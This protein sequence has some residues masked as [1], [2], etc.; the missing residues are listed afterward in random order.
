MI[1]QQYIVTNKTCAILPAK[2]INHQAIVLEEHTTIKVAQTPLEIIKHSC[3][4]YWADYEGRRASVIK[5]L[6]YKQKTPIPVSV[7][8]KLCFLPTH[9]PTHMNNCWINR[10]HVNRWG[11]IQKDERTNE[12]QTEIL[13]NNWHRL[14]LGISI[15]TLQQQIERAFRVMVESG[16]VDIK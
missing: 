10:A 15:H 1:Q 3:T 2:E 11:R 12:K 16:M 14:E 4:H 5:N 9:S 7:K 8:H 13:F 6:A